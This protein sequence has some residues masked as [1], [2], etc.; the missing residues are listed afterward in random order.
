MGPLVIGQRSSLACW[1]FPG[2]VCVVVDLEKDDT[3]VGLVN[4]GAA[5]R[6]I[7]ASVEHANTL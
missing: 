6:H 5:L 7:H 4:S 2:F 1:E 3:L